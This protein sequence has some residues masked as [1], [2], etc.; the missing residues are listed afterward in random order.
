MASLSNPSKF[1][2]IYRIWKDT[3]ANTGLKWSN[4]NSEDIIIERFTKSQS[5]EEI[6]DWIVSVKGAI[7]TLTGFMDFA[8][9]TGIRFVEAV[10]SYNLIVDLSEHGDLTEYYDVEKA[11]LEHYRF[12][13]LFIRRSKKIFISFISEDLVELVKASRRFSKSA[14]ENRIKRSGLPSRFGDLREYWATYM[15]KYLKQPEI[16][17]LQGRVSTSV[18]MRNYFNPAWIKDLKDRILRSTEE[19]LMELQHLS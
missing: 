18:F 16:D 5:P 8:T 15:T 19:I 1:L 3:V 14:I 9:A 4:G 7:P 13:E 6:K 12:S 17:F 10:R 2:G 11:L